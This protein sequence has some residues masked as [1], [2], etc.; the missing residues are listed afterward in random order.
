VRQPWPKASE[1]YLWDADKHDMLRDWHGTVLD[2]T[3]VN[4]NK[5][6]SK[7][8]QERQASIRRAQVCTAHLLHKYNV[9]SVAWPCLSLHYNF[10]ST[11]GD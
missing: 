1:R 3:A 6:N 10:M 11:T 5:D 8:S 7:V 9:Q 2:T 4:G